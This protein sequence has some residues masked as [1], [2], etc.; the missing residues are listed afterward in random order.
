MKRPPLRAKMLSHGRA[1]KKRKT[2]K[3][4]DGIYARDV[5]EAVIA[6]DKNDVI[7]FNVT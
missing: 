5:R 1:R 7:I 6:Y 2:T 4:T 3:T